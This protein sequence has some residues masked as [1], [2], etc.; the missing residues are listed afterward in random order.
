MKVLRVLLGL[1]SGGCLFIGCVPGIMLGLADQKQKKEK[2]RLM[3]EYPHME[4]EFLKSLAEEEARL[5][6]VGQK[7]VD[8]L[9]Q[10]MIPAYAAGAPKKHPARVAGEVVRT[11]LIVARQLIR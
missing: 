1:M 7:C 5:V 8:R 10:L 2:L 3:K 6:D 4:A 9:K 11:G